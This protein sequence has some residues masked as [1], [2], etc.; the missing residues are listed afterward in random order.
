MSKK[1]KEEMSKE[2]KKAAPAKATQPVQAKVAQPA[3]AKVTQP[4]QAKVT[5]PAPAKDPQPVPAKATQPAPV[6]AKDSQAHA[7]E[8]HPASAQAKAPVV[9]AKM[10]IFVKLLT[11]K[12]ITLEVDPKD[13]TLSVKQQLTEHA[14]IPPDEQRLVFSGKQLEDKY[15]LGEHGVSKESMLFLVLKRNLPNENEQC[16]ACG[17][18]FY[19]G[20]GRLL[21]SVGTSSSEVFCE[22]CLNPEGSNRKDI[23][24]R[25]PYGTIV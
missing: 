22:R 2:E 13:S 4:V 19:T 12:T 16:K 21:R 9:A 23:S 14:G 15:I 24:V 5:Q 6:Q 1:D 20:S 8:A 10:K 25:K 7:K 11:G 3:P 17:V 18:V